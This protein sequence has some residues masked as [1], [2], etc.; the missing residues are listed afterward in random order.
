VETL[1]PDYNKFEWQSTLREALME[2]N[3]ERLKIKVAKAEEAIFQRLQSLNHQTDGAEERHALQDA[4]N[5]LL[6]LKREALKYP[7]WRQNESGSV[8]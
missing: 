1:N 2:L 3:P 6:T 5:M 7:D 8:K 4:S